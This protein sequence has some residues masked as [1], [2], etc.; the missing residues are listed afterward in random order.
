MD[1]KL[2]FF[3]S[4]V[5]FILNHHFCTILYYISS[6]VRSSLK[7]ESDWENNTVARR[8][9]GSELRISRH[10]TPRDATRRASGHATPTSGHYPGGPRLAHHDGLELLVV[11]GAGAVLIDLVDDLVDVCLGERLVQRH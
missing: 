9:V 5:H 1:N 3:G 4:V 7:R 2:A 8:R 6:I 10:A 11:D